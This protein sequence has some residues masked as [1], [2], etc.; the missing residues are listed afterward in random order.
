MGNVS[1]AVDF[2]ISSEVLKNISKLKRDNHSGI[3][4][5]LFNYLVFF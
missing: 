4:I 1:S 5:L 3:L 2:G